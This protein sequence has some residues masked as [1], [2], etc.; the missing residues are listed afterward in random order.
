MKK[1]KYRNVTVS[2]L[3][4]AGSTTLAKKIEKLL[5]W[6]YFSGGDFL[7][8]HAVKRGLFDPKS[9]LHHDQSIMN[10]K[11][12]RDMDYMMRDKVSSE[13][14]NILDSWLSGFM[15][16]EVKGTLKVLAFCSE[17]AVRVDRIM[18]RDKVSVENAK[19]HIFEREEK[20]I[21]KWKRM[22]K[23]EWNKW[24]IQRGVVEKAAKIDFW[25]SKLYDLVIDTYSHSRE[26]TLR[27][28]L[29]ALGY[30]S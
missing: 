8:A 20:N 14:G 16:Q 6:K 9:N 10:D 17:D 19:K 4:G 22:Y 7:R 13:S 12:D 3:P 25:N 26:E 21:A 24:V 11:A 29:E 23:S 18:N 27:L 5:G 15:A 28:T 2:G 1:L 30:A